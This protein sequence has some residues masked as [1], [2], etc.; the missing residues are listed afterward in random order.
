MTEFVVDASVALKWFVP[1]V[2]SDLAEQLLVSGAK[3][4][5]PRFLAVETINAAWKNWRKKLIDRAVVEMAGDRLPALVEVWHADEDL[6]R[7]ALDL[8]LDFE[9]L[10]A[11]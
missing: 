2:D 3:L 5:A 7:D 1:E 6:L 4:H 9:G 10:K 11:R 8:A